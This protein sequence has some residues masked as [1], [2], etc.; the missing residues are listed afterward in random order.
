MY[1]KNIKKAQKSLEPDILLM[2]WLL[3]ID[4][5]SCKNTLKEKILLYSINFNKE[6]KYLYTYCLDKEEEIIVNKIYQLKLEE[7]EPIGPGFTTEFKW[8]DLDRIVID[9]NNKPY[10]YTD[11]FE[12]FF[13]DKSVVDKI[14]NS[15]KIN[16][17]L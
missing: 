10:K 1:A 2:L 6:K 11:A 7:E 17:K 4:I 13:S 14:K 5:D 8:I 16:D 9:F 3:S 15:I 12:P